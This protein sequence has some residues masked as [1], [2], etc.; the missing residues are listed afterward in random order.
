MRKKTPS[1]SFLKQKIPKMYKLFFIPLLILFILKGATASSIRFYE[2]NITSVRRNPDCSDHESSVLVVNN[3]LTGIPIYLNKGDKAQ[4][5]VRNNILPNRPVY[6]GVGM[7]VT[8]HFHGIRQISSVGSDGVPYLTQRALKPGES[9]LHEFVVDDQVGTFFYHA[10]AGLEEMSVFGP[11]IIYDSEKAVP[12]SRIVHGGAEKLKDGPYTYD[13]E[14][15][16]SLS[17]WWHSDRGQFEAYYLG[18]NFTQI[19]EAQTILVNGQGIYQDTGMDLVSNC[20]GYAVVPVEPHK[21]YRLRIIGAMTFRTLGFA[22]ANHLMQVIEVDG[23]FV[24]PYVVDYLEL[25]PGQRMSVLIKTNHPVADYG[26]GLV[27][28]WAAG[29]PAA[30]NGH[31]IL[32]YQEPKS[33]FVPWSFN[34]KTAQTI[35]TRVLAPSALQPTF[36]VNDTI[37]WYWSKLTPY[38]GP[39][40]ITKV[41]SNRTI[42]LVGS[43]K[44][45]NGLT[46][47]YVNDV[48]FR[49]REDRV[50]LY[51]IVNKTR[52]LS[53]KLDRD[54]ITGFDKVLGT[55]PLDHLE[56]VDIVIQTR[57]AIGEPCR[58]HPWHTH[59]HSHWE[60]AYGHGEYVEERDG[61]TRNVPNPI[62]KDL[63]LVYPGKD[64]IKYITPNQT[65]IGCGWSKIRILAVSCLFVV[66]K[67]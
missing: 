63:T 34:Y 62:Y 59:G 15:I 12:S 46:R 49:E 27:R 28:R 57:H 67:E 17:E 16:I 64:E 20:R 19:F 66:N 60:I 35:G 65:S 13:D 54:P 10:H 14:R 41:K 18:P 53:N 43:Q 6:G 7:Q 23:D 36:P 38:N 58:S 21:V 30:T 33:N 29:V 2:L 48:S 32:R 3:Q 39:D 52:A 4:I 50:I 25:S 45:T 8:V 42:K 55:Y 56:V 47:W 37:H 31:A 24:R 1:F 5:L 51:D 22:I 40:P 44:I 61:L 11:I 26:I 9:I